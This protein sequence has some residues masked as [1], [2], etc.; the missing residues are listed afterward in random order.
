MYQ[1]NQIIREGD[2]WIRHTFNKKE[3]LTECAKCHQ[4]IL[5][6]DAK[7]RVVSRIG[8]LTFHYECF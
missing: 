5:T 3:L 8:T 2:R 1:F 7:Q 6:P 4:P